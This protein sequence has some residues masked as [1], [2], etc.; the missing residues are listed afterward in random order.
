MSK[1]SAADASSCCFQSQLMPPGSVFAG[2]L[3]QLEERMAHDQLPQGAVCD[4]F[5][6]RPGVRLL[7]R[8]TGAAPTARS[9]G[10]RLH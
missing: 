3:G 6:G 2:R 10:D 4:R 8:H 7:R 5:L 1:A 9:V